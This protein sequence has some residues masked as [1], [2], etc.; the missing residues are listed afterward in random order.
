MLL[1]ASQPFL[2]GGW[3]GGRGEGGGGQMGGM[4][5]ERGVDKTCREGVVDRLILSLS[6]SLCC[7][8][9]CKVCLFVCLCVE[10]YSGGHSPDHQIRLHSDIPALPQTEKHNRSTRVCVRLISD[11]TKIYIPPTCL[12]IKHV[13]HACAHNKTCVRA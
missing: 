11:I 5:Q 6:L 1:N 4:V 3:G 13:L 8:F 12:R 2:P 7:V 9:G 10:G